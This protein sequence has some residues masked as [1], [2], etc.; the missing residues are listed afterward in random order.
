MFT[1]ELAGDIIFI[2]ENTPKGEHEMSE[3]VTFKSIDEAIEVYV[4]TRD[5]LRAHQK[6]AKQKEEEL[7]EFMDKI[8]MWLRDR[9]DELGVDSFKT[10]HGTAYRNVKPTYRVGDWDA[11]IN[12]VIESG[13]TQC[14]EKRVAKRAAAEI[15][16]TDEVVP[17][18]LDYSLEVEFNVLRPGKKKEDD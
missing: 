16:K 9:A 1:F 8:S 5:A 11:F 13:N 6:A 4:D 15:H 3:P 7:K 17:P 10:R 12:W 14:L 2:V 18:G